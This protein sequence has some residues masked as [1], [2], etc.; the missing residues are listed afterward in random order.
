[1]QF[2]IPALIG[3]GGVLGGGLLA[4]FT[5]RAGWRHEAEG[6]H[7]Q[8]V[9]KQRTA[10]YLAFLDRC[11]ECC[12]NARDQY[13]ND[14][15]F[16]FEPDWF[17]SVYRAMLRVEVFGS[18]DVAAEAHRTAEAVAKA[19]NTDL[20]GQWAGTFAPGSEDEV[21]QPFINAMRR[22]LGIAGG[23]VPRWGSGQ[24]QDGGTGKPAAK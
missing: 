4:T 8:W 6:E 9:R 14:P 11:R 12:V 22:D 2:V 3:V 10:A 5:T 20:R 19:I 21:L 18:P 13:R 1:M 17:D 16:A 23:D 7:Q 15:S 24:S